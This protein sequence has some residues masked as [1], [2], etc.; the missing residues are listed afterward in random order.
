MQIQNK[1]NKCSLGEEETGEQKHSQNVI[2]PKLL[3]MVNSLYFGLY[4]KHI[5][6]QTCVV[7]FVSSL[8]NQVR[9]NAAVPQMTR[10]IL[11]DLKLSLCKNI[12][13]NKAKLTIVK[14]TAACSDT[15]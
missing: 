1:S 12:Q 11:F 15:V 7:M 4:S 10:R 13:Y 2:V 9:S 5:I 14:H 6:I 8:L 3:M